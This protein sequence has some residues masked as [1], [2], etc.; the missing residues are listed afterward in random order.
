MLKEDRIIRK[1]IKNSAQNVLLIGSVFAFCSC[2]INY[3]PKEEISAIYEKKFQKE[4]IKNT[5]ED[6]MGKIKEKK[7]VNLYEEN[8]DKRM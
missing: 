6:V 3:K 5:R 7:R 1:T 8:K 4:V 2:Y